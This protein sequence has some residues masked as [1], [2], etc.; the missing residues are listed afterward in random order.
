VRERERE[1]EKSLLGSFHGKNGG[2]RALSKRAV[3]HRRVGLMQVRLRGRACPE[4]DSP[5]VVACFS[6][7]RQEAEVGVVA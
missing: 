1:R 2:S 5:K 3:P 6:R 7:F 4:R